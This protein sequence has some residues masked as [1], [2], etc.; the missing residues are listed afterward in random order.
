M[1][2]KS[3]TPSQM[4]T[5]VEID[6]VDEIKSTWQMAQIINTAP[7]HQLPCKFSQSN[8]STPSHFLSTVLLEH[9]YTCHRPAPGTPPSP[10]LLIC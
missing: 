8:R 2:W 1:L 6:A 5:L 7:L 4:K 10:G 9:T 3:I